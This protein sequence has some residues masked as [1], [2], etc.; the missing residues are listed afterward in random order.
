MFV[1][2]TLTGL[3]L[4]GL[5]FQST[6]LAGATTGRLATL[7]LTELVAPVGFK[8]QLTGDGAMVFAEG[9]GDKTAGIVTAVVFF[10]FYIVVFIV[11]VVLLFACVGRQG[12]HVHYEH[13]APVEDEE[14]LASSD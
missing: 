11:F 2:G 3:A 5:M 14:E 12:N 7:Q 10:G 4:R 8:A 13:A 1:N 6:M 9:D